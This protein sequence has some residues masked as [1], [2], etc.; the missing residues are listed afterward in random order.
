MT[1]TYQVS[2]KNFPDLK[3]HVKNHP[4]NQKLWDGTEPRLM[5]Y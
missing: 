1:H 3:E 5:A 4:H 2:V